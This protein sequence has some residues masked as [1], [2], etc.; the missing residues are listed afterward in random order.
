MVLRQEWDEYTKNWLDVERDINLVWS[1][2]QNNP[3][4]LLSYEI[5]TAPGPWDYGWGNKEKHS[6]SYDPATKTLFSTIELPS[7]DSWVPSSRTLTI[8]DAQMN[9]IRMQ[10][11]EW[12][13]N[14]WE[15]RVEMQYALTFNA[16][17]AL[18]EKTTTVRRT[19]SGELENA[20][21]EVYSDFQTF[22]VT[23]AAEQLPESSLS[24]FPNPTSGDLKITL[25]DAGFQK[26]QVLVLDLQG[27]KVYDATTTSASINSGKQMIPLHHLSAGMYILR[28]ITDNHKEISRR[29]VKN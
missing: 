21:K 27:R 17:Y 9:P 26:A 5:Q 15:F 12:V 25:T 24:I 14:V 1:T 20:Y 4:K 16:E 2:D 3:F 19:N 11:R 10:A 28:I 22:S 6:N 13:S 7:G 8:F 29:V 23:G 18:T